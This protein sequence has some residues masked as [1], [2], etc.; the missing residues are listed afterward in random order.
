MND[1]SG[2]MEELACGLREDISASRGTDS[3]WEAV[4]PIQPLSAWFSSPHRVV[5]K[6]SDKN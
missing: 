5:T 6:L 1:Y 3:V 2:H 4:Q